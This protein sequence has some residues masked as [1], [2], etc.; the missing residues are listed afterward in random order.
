MYSSDLLEILSD[1]AP[2]K[3]GDSRN[4]MV[5]DHFG[6]I[7]AEVLALETGTVVC[8]LPAFVRLQ[9]TGRDRARYLHNF[10]TNDVNNLATGRGCEAFFTD[11]KARVLAHG[12]VLALPDVHEIW[13][14]PGDEDRLLNHLNRYIITEDV[15][16]SS[17]SATTSMFAVAGPL[18]ESVIV[19]AAS[20][21]GLSDTG[22][23][24]TG[25]CWQSGSTAGL[26]VR[27][28][29]TPVALLSTS[30]AASLWQQL[31]EQGAVPAGMIVF[32]HLRILEGFP[33][34]GVDLSDQNLAP[35]ADRNQQAISYTKGCYLGQEPIAR[36]DAM[37]H[38]N[39]RLFR[40]TAT[41]AP[42][43]AAPE[44]SDLPLVTSRSRI[45]TPSGP[46]LV[47]LSV[48]QAADTE[49]PARD[50]QQ[51]LLNLTITPT[52]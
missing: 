7:T 38:V 15:T 13:M 32:D 24:E 46:A 19:K 33:I 37:G 27:W 9:V 52:S 42:S 1:S 3:V 35:E 47:Q 4:N 50:S 49:V 20:D 34:I 41:A 30:A 48:R 25:Q 14:L 23:I 45:G 22:S 17:V 12:Y 2:V 51:N 8:P 21:T 26:M 39:R 40:C 5:I 43:A 18:T 16:I 36:I 28:N 10:C 11:V 31:T 29:D 44:S 6:D